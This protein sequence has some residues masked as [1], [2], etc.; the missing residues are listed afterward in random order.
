MI[1]LPSKPTAPKPA[2]EAYER[3]LTAVAEAAAAGPL[4]SGELKSMA[5]AVWQALEPLPDD[6][7]PSALAGGG[8]VKCTL[9]GDQQAVFW[10]WRVL[11]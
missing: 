11:L 4:P 8:G 1:L 9:G 2:R 10:A 7:L 6:S 5:A 3:L